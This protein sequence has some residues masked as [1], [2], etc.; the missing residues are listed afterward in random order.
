VYRDLESPD[1]PRPHFAG[2]GSIIERAPLMPGAASAVDS[3]QDLGELRSQHGHFGRLAA[4]LVAGMVHHPTAALD[5][6]LVA[7]SAT[8]CATS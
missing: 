1:E 4:D 3:A 6:L 8:R 7:W 2:R 5:Q